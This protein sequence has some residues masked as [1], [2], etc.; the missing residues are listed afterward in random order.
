MKST[1]SN[2]FIT[3]LVPPLYIVLPDSLPSSATHCI[4]TPLSEKPLPSPPIAQ[5]LEGSSLGEA[6][7][8]LDA[9]ERPLRR[10]P[11][12]MPH[13]QEDWPVLSPKKSG[14]DLS[15]RGDM[16][17]DCCSDSPLNT[18]LTAAQNERY[19]LN[20][21]KPQSSP[22]KVSENSSPS[23]QIRRKQLPSST[24]RQQPDTVT[25]SKNGVAGSERETAEEIDAVAQ[26]APADI[27]SH[28]APSNLSASAAAVEK[29]LYEAGS[30]GNLH[31]TRTASLRARLSAGQIIKD[32]PTT[33]SKVVGFTDFTAFNQVSGQ[34]LLSAP[35]ESRDRPMSPTGRSFRSNPSKESLRGTRA[36]GQVVGADRLLIG[37]RSSHSSLPG[38]FRAA[39]PLPGPQPPGR[40]APAVPTATATAES[41]PPS[42][43]EAKLSEPRRSSIPVF[44]HNASNMILQPEPERIS[45]AAK[46]K[47]GSRF[48]RISRGEFGIYE[49]CLADS[50][51]ADVVADSHAEAHVE[52]R[53]EIAQASQQLSGLEAIE[54]S[55]KQDFHV[56]RLSM[57]SP[58]HGPVLKISKSADRLIMG[59]DSDKENQYGV[60]IKKNN[61]HA[62]VFGTP[63]IAHNLHSAESVSESKK[64]PSRSA[65]SH[66]FSQAG[67]LVGRVDKDSREK[68]V[69]SADFT[70]SLATGH[71][72]QSAARLKTRAV[73]K[74]TD[75]SIPDD[76]FFDAH[77]ICQKDP[78]AVVDVGQGANKET[79]SA[80]DPW[81]SP[82]PT[83]YNSS[84]CIPMASRIA[85]KQSVFQE[86][87][88]KNSTT[89]LLSMPTDKPV[90]DDT[91]V[92]KDSTEVLA[93]NERLI[94]HQPRTP[95]K[96]D[97]SASNTNYTIFPPRSSSR[98]TPPNYT[99]G[100]S[101]KVSP[102]S[103]LGNEK[104]RTG[105]PYD[106]HND[107]GASSGLATT[108]LDVSG[109][110]IK[111]DSVARE[112]NISQT[113][114]AKGML[115]NIRG[116]F[117]KRTSDNDSF[118]AKPKKKGKHQILAT[119][120]GSPFPPLS[121][122]HPVYR[123]TLASNS[124][125]AGN[126][127][128]RS[129]LGLLG[130][131]ATP[132]LVSPLPSEISTTTTLAMQLLESVRTERSS[133]KKERCLEL[134]TILVE[135]ITQARDAEK[136]V[137]EAK[138][139]ARKAEVAY[140][141]CKKSVGDI[142]IRVKGWRDEM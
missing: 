42:Q 36:P 94:D 128:R 122:I 49:D 71:I 17:H 87:I 102:I 96:S 142:A 5:I 113:S 133:P 104:S 118:S 46:D 26:D 76:P 6:R 140:A 85:E 24:P 10:S 55:P 141:M 70:Y 34:G 68:K 20:G 123:P 12:G 60:K 84:G 91:N 18:P 120:G 90:A 106:L 111:R 8:L 114:V 33:K 75:A 125:S 72:H 130:I 16:V 2:W 139:A 47:L 21:S 19:P 77:S 101:S 83:T 35:D 37:Y 3:Q 100:M 116:L 108:P 4:T 57:A 13:K 58:E 117:H 54:E 81:I 105:R 124:R 50:C 28:A 66:G 59:S 61:L 64:L 30:H 65:S 135:A 62:R 119:T 115:S 88:A 80:E 23:Y 131:P 129:E 79:A 44:R 82:L 7:S 89:M 29:S 103:P 41:I 137:E 73:R 126:S 93:K 127:K 25:I 95:E 22:D 31:Q 43:L 110:A 27:P 97:L 48:K 32:S 53:S 134:G 136:A 56:K 132:S 45:I 112:S 1:G 78:D 86:H 51:S 63:S 92:V 107:L 52:N 39:S 67:S 121:E 15:L 74:N 138:Q 99:T 98:T 9:S 14:I 109:V 11:P 69:K 40:C 38:D